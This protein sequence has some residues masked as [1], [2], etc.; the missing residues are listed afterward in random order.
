MMKTIIDGQLKYATSHEGYMVERFS[1][2]D[3]YW[4]PW[5]PNAS[6][7]GRVLDMLKDKPLIKVFNKIDLMQDDTLS[8]ADVH[9]SAVTGAG[10]EKLKAL[11]YEKSFGARGE[12]AAFLI[13]ERHFDALQRA[14]EALKKAAKD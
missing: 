2:H 11:L 1:D 14:K 8:D 9:T 4:C 12:D 10:I 5:M 3:A 13:E 6:A 7:N